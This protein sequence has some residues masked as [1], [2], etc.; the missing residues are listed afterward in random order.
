MY[1]D[2]IMTIMISISQNYRQIIKAILAQFE[3]FDINRLRINN[4]ALIV[5]CGHD[6]ETKP[7]KPCSCIV[8]RKHKKGK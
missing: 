8:T 1:H 4:I 7:L 6:H 5:P 2:T 3:D